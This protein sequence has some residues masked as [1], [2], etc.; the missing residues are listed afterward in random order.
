MTVLVD[1][2]NTR[3]KWATLAGRRLVA[4]RHA[5]CIAMSLDAAVAAFTAALPPQRDASSP[6]TSPASR[7][8]SGSQRSSRATR[9]V[10]RARRDC[11][12]S[13][14][15]CAAPTRIRAGSAS[16]AGWRCSL[17]I[18]RAAGAPACVLSAGTA[19]T[20]DAVDGGGRISAD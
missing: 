4:P 10:A 2:G 9:R 20:F 14:S 6:R 1:I 7:S 17:R 13:A 8:R 18:E 19:V 12:P 5:P 16:T 15:A 3:I 11:R